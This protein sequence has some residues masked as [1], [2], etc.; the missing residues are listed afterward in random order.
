MAPVAQIPLP[1]SPL[2]T[3]PPGTPAGIVRPSHTANGPVYHLDASAIQALL[4]Q[5]HSL[6]RSPKGAGAGADKKRQQGRFKVSDAEK[7][8]MKAMCGITSTTV[9]DEGFPKWYRDIFNKNQDKKDDSKERLLDSIRC[10]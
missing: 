2:G 8:Q 9:S 6:P 3:N 10:G 7:G 1:P 5:A 4:T